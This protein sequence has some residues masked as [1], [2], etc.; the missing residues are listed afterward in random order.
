VPVVV[1]FGV[2]DPETGPLAKGVPQHISSF[3][4]RD[5]VPGPLA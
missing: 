2:H 1:T 3:G 5:P 4:V